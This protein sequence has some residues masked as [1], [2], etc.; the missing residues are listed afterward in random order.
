MLLAAGAAHAAEHPA[1]VQA[2]VEQGVKVEAEFEAPGG[3]PGY[4]A[5]YRGAPMVFYMTPDGAQ[6]I[7][8]TMLGAEGENLSVDHLRRYLP[9]P[10]FNE[11]WPLLEKAAWVGDGPSNA[12]RIVYVFSDPNC[13]YCN[14]FWRATRPYVG[15]DLQ[16]RHIMVGVLSQS[17]AGK[18]AAILAA[19]DPAA[20]LARHEENHSAGGIEPLE[21]IPFEIEQHL[22]LNVEL[23]R[24]LGARGTPAIFYRDREGKGRRMIGLPSEQAL[25]EEI[26]QL[27]GDR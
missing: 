26:L 2:L 3:M 12:K 4:A 6:V 8:G 27:S 14:A 16:V 17:S 9:E 21:K 19:E 5:P 22:K 1:P 25:K 20:A 18:A 13:P 23:M 10:D 15:K 7:L 11:A 24:Q